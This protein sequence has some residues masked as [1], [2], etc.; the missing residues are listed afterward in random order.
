MTVRLDPVQLQRFSFEVLTAAGMAVEPAQSVATGLLEAQ[1][2]GHVTHGLTLLPDYVEE[3]LSGS[4]TADGS[5]LELSSHGAVANWDG[6]RLPGLWTTE[7]AVLEAEKRALTFGI[8]AISVRNS[9]HIACLATFLETPARRN[10]MVMIFSSDPSDAHVAPF[11]GLTPVMTPN[12]IAVGIPTDGDPVMVDVSTSITTAG[13]CG[14]R[15][16]EGADLPGTW[17]MDKHGAPTADPKVMLDS[18]SILPIGG[19][20]HGHK[21]FG[22][23]L[24]V[25]ALTQGL[26]G[27]GRADGPTQWGAS[28]LVLVL[29]PALFGGTSAFNTQTGWLANACRISPTRSGTSAVRLPGEAGLKKKRLAMEEGVEVDDK[30][31]ATLLSLG[32]HQA[33]K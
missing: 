2:L 26:A 32:L 5:P 21:G 10:K 3:V 19:L 15:R 25:E 23:S 9:H 1:L 30:L 14:I 7:L 24:M 22:L 16:S 4:M 33:C 6:K 13:L 8:G 28:V 18:G 27:F 17:L 12:P 29:D 31:Y 11:G 20:D